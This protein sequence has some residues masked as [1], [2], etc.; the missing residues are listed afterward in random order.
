M[1]YEETLQYLFN[2]LPIFTRVGA[3]AYKADLSNT[4]LLCESLGHPEHKFKSIHVAGTNGKGSCSHML[5]SVFQ[6]AGY[7]TGLYTSPHVIDFRER[8]KVNGTDIGKEWIIQCTKK[9][10]PCIEKIQP[11][12]FEVT[13]A[14]A[15]AFFAEEEVDIA[16]I[17]AGLGGLLDSTNVIIPELSVITN[18][19]YD[20]TNL[21]GDT[22]MKIAVQKAGIIKSNVPV[23]LGETDPETVTVFRETASQ[24]HSLIVFADQQFD[25]IHAT[26][27]SDGLLIKL[28]DTTDSAEYMFRLDLTGNYQLKNLKTVLA[29]IALLRKA[30]WDLSD[31]AVETGLANVK[32]NTGIKGRFEQ[33]MDSP[34][35]IVDVAHNEAGIRE[36]MQQ[37]MQ[38]PFTRLH[39]VTGFVQDKA[40]ENVLT[41]FPSEATY[42]FTQAEIPRALPFEVLVE[43]AAR[44]GLSGNGYRT[45]KQAVSNALKN[46]QTGDLILVTGSFFILADVYEMTDSKNNQ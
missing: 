26:H 11:S 15:F 12:F 43:K 40:V 18:I 30:E 8:I 45:V 44:A 21:L 24:K 31:K 46:A 20:H 6:S 28:S 3:A 35:L 5:A 19:S 34:K 4:L 41:L 23:V 29:A 7:K 38:L 32:K 36:L 25:M 33:L 17:E 13:V 22:L 37:I 2:K 16:I 39:I 27:E 9:M 42:Y 10:I 14:M 1:S